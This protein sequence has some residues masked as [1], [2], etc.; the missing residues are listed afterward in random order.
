MKDASVNAH[1]AVKTQQRDATTGV[2]VRHPQGADDGAP[3]GV[4]LSLL[5]R[6][7]N[8][9]SAQIQVVS[10]PNGPDRAILSRDQSLDRR[11]T[12]VILA[13]DTL[14]HCPLFLTTADDLG[15]TRARRPF[16]SPARL[17]GGFRSRL[18][19]DPLAG[20]EAGRAR[21]TRCRRTPSR[22]V[23]EGCVRWAPRLHSE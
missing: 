6:T 22:R 2:Q 10:Y 16:A 18:R 1:V 23:C 7:S 17:F 14:Q 19:R 12:I 3:I 9:K 20:I 15:R 13:N 21:R 5:A 8:V 4:G 11:P